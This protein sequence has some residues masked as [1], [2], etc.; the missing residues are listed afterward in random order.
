MSDALTIRPPALPGGELAVPASVAGQG[1]RAAMRYIEFFTAQIRNPNTR[2]AYARAASAFFAWCEQRGLLLPAIQPVHVATYIEQLSRE[3]SAP[4][5]KQQLAAIRMLFDWL[6]V[7]Q[8]VPHNPAS[9]VRG[10]KHSALPRCDLHIV[11]GG[12][13][14]NLIF[15][16]PSSFLLAV[17]LRPQVRHLSCKRFVGIGRL[18]FRVVDACCLPLRCLPLAPAVFS[19]R[20]FCAGP[21]SRSG[22]PLGAC[23]RVSV[24]V[25]GRPQ[26][27]KME[28]VKL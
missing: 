11:D 17:K 18:R 19:C 25:V 7:G 22:N 24:G 5:V 6:V 9:A 23:H 10:P 15:H 26:G 14:S 12:F 28:V 21:R 3:R 13:S 1:D 8:V 27:P 4:T 2:A 20:P 16:A